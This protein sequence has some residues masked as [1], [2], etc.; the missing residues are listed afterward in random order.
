[1]YDKLEAE[2][3]KTIC[4]PKTLAYEKE[5]RNI[6]DKGLRHEPKASQKP[7]KRYA[8]TYKQEFLEPVD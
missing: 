8:T 1:M 7:L 2:R 5:P 6:M 3:A 4:I